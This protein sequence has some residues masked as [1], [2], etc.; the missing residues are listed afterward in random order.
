[1]NWEHCW[2]SSL[3]LVLH[4]WNT[5]SKPGI[6]I[7]I[8]QF[9]C[10][11]SLRD[12]LVQSHHSGHTKSGTQA[13][14]SLPC[15]KCNYCRFSRGRDILLPK[16]TTWVPKYRTMCQM[17]CIVYNIKYNVM[18][19]TVYWLNKTPFKW[20]REYVSLISNKKKL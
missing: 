13:V 11:R 17:I 8:K 18:H 20:I 5:H 16:N 1:M 15:G 2:L 19:S 12:S 4:E 14:G 6:L 10:S 7:A 9:K 3:H